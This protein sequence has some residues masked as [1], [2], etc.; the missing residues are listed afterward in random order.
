MPGRKRTLL[1][2]AAEVHDRRPEQALADDADASRAAGARVLLVEDDLLDERHAAAAVLGGPT[3]PDPG[4][5]PELLLPLPAL[6]EQLV[7]VAGTAAPAHLREA[8]VETVDE[9]RA[10]LGAEAFLFAG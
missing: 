3:E 5:A 2:V 6:V 7:L 10:R 8:A 9:P 1:V 4:V